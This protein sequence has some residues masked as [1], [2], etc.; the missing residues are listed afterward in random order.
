MKIPRE[1]HGIP[2]NDIDKQVE[3]AGLVSRVVQCHICPR[4]MGRS[5]VLGV[6]NGSLNAKVMFVA[7]APGRKGADVSGIPLSGDQTGRNFDMLLDCC[8]IRREEVF[9]TNSVLCNPR[10][11]KNRNATPMRQ[12]VK[13]CS[14][15]LRSTIDIVQPKIVVTLGS[16]ALSALNLVEAHKVALASNVGQRIAW[17]GRWLIPLYHPGP[18]ARLHRPFD[19]QKSDFMALAQVINE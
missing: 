6:G 9:I 12:E 13:D 11:A 19:V 10:D 5:R 17:N 14:V 18:R 15:H 2:L 3:F 1:E 8:G 7:E 16:I 4:M